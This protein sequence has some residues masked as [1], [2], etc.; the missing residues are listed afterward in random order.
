MKIVADTNVLISA[1]ISEGPPFDIISMVFSGAITIVF[2]RETYG[3]L[4]EVLMTREPFDRI[5]REVRSSYL[6]HLAERA[7]WVRP[8]QSP[9][10]SRDPDDNK[11]LDAAYSAQVDYLV[12]GDDDLL[13]LLN[14]GPMKIR[15]PAQFL[16]EFHRA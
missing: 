2:S 3:E 13:V 14:V 9:A 7:I 10:R 8:T 5:S 4:A 1:A 15:S 11:F 6:G 12:T 16:E